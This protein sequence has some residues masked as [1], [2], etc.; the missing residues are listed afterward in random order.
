MTLTTTTEA[1]FGNRV[2]EA[3]IDYYQKGAPKVSADSATECAAMCEDTIGCTHF[4]FGW[5]ECYFKT[6]SS[7]YRSHP[8]M[9]SGNVIGAKPGNPNKNINPTCTLMSKVNA[10]SFCKAQGARLCTQD[11][12]YQQVPVVAGCDYET[13]VNGW[14][15]TKCGNNKFIMA[16]AGKS[17]CKKKRLKAAPRCCSTEPPAPAAQVV[18][19]KATL[20]PAPP[21]APTPAATTK[22]ATTKAAT[23]KAA[24]T[25]KTCTI[26]KGVDFKGFD[27]SSTKV[28]SASQCATVCIG[29]KKCTHFTRANNGVCYLKTSGK[30]KKKNNS[31]R[32]LVSGICQ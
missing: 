25:K 2:F 23:T 22:V 26:V 8:N 32:K 3:G 29:T 21:P 4:T 27:L 13:G 17:D 28:S 16:M 10:D 19:A 11:D 20:P 6:S 31:T 14:T 12:V 7:G 5:G 24:T 9:V 1:P 30:N 15:G 18:T